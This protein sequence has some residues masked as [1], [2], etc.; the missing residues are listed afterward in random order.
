MIDLNAAAPVWRYTD[1]MMYR[2]RQTNA[3]I[4]ADGQVLVT[5]GT[6]TCG[7]D[8]AAGSI[9]VP[10][11]WNPATGHWSAMASNAVRRIYHSTAILLPDARVLVAGGTDQS[12][13]EVFTPPYLYAADGSPAPRPAFSVTTTT[14]GYGQIVNLQTGD[15]GS[16]AKVT[17]VRFGAATHAFNQS[18]QLNTLGFAVA[19][20]GQSL[21]V[22][23]PSAGRLAPP[24]PYLLFIV[25]QQG[26]PSV[27]RLVTLH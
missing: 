5:G 17:L 11:L 16:I 20:D 23:M 8:D 19:V 4:L 7:F 21:N 14:V 27:A 15:A 26:I 18:Q 12:T 22:T 3:T 13:A 24:G 25:N 9:Y 6:S 10:E 1:S 2:R